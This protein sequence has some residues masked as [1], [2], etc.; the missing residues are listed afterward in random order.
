MAVVAAAHFDPRL[1]GSH[2]AAIGGELITVM[3]LVALVSHK[4]SPK[5]SS[6]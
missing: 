5:Q 4:H 3:Y 1:A 2:L 6:V